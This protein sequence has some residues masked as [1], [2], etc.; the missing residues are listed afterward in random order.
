[1]EEKKEESFKTEK[2]HLKIFSFVTLRKE[3]YKYTK[4]KQNTRFQFSVFLFC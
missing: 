2:T 4:K 1:M 3:N